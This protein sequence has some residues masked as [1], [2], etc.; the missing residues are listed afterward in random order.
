MNY[1]TDLIE[2][3]LKYICSVIP[4]RE[5]TEYFKKYPKEFSKLRPGFRVKSLRENEVTQTLIAFRN[6]DFI[7]SFIVKHINRWLE[8]IQSALDEVKQT[9]LDTEETYIHVLAR[10]V[11][12]H[13][14]PLYFKI[15]EEEKS[16]EYLC[17]LS[18]AVNQLVEIIDEAD[19]LSKK[20]T[21]EIAEKESDYRRLKDST[22]DAERVIERL[23]TQI[24]NAALNEETMSSTISQK[25]AEIQELRK[26]IAQMKSEVIR[27]NEEISERAEST[28]KSHAMLVK[29]KD[30]LT[31]Q[32][33]ELEKTISL[34]Q[35][36]ITVLADTKSTISILETQI[37]EMKASIQALTEANEAYKG[38]IDE[39][40]QSLSECAIQQVANT[41]IVNDGTVSLSR[42]VVMPCRPVDMEDFDEYF[43]YNLNNIGFG[44]GTEASKLF[45]RFI[46]KIAFSGMPLLIKHGP[47]INLANCLA[48]TIYGQ[49][50]A[51]VLTYSGSAGIDT[52]KDFL[53]NTPDRVVCIAGFVGNCNEIEL[54]PLLEQYRNKIIILTYMYDRTLN[55][56]PMEILTY[57]RYIN[58]DEFKPLLRIKDITEDP[59]EI[60]EEP[61]AFSS[62]TAEETRYQRIFREISEQCGLSR[63]VINSVSD[64]IDSEEYMNSVLLFSVLPYV[65]KVIQ[66]N[67]YNSSKRLQKYA[68]ESG[69]C[70]NKGIMLGWFG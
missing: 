43:N 34:Y 16:E 60:K 24:T 45:V 32:I 57:V 17:L 40:E 39:L 65:S 56:I 54:L 29:E 62:E 35:E 66:L 4:Y 51:A 31:E 38:R 41:Q 63:D 20:H 33:D 25:D 11:F 8:E 59:S 2:A 69:K 14:V 55:Y 5:T 44:D 7:S 52:I 50:A 67:P 12:S 23:R 36:Q 68:G 37:S 53:I 28:E 6:R 47:G 3:D 70:P 18:A 46:E 1:I 26:D 10:S 42:E 9:G 15:I 48:N 22:D 27:L 21:K 13:N 61:Y 30:A 19:E 58:V 49:K 64:S